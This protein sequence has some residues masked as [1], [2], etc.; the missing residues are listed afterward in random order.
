MTKKIA[1]IIIIVETLL[2]IV[3][4]LIGCVD[5]QT[6]LLKIVSLILLIISFSGILYLFAKNKQ[7]SKRNIVDL[8]FA[9]IVVFVNHSMLGLVLGWNECPLM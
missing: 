2:A 7:K 5:G 9:I 3:I 8:I 6:L 1:Y 4:G